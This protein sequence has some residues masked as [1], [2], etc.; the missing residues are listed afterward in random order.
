MQLRLTT[1]ITLIAA[2]GLVAACNE[3]SD[4]TLAENGDET[5]IIEETG[6]ET[7]STDGAVSSDVVVP[8]GAR[9]QGATGG[10]LEQ[11]MSG[12]SASSAAPEEMAG[13][14]SELASAQPA[15]N[16]P[17]DSEADLP[18]E[19]AADAGEALEEQEEAIEAAA[20]A[21]APAGTDAAEAGSTE[22]AD[23][24]A[25]VIEG[26]EAEEVAGGSADVEQPAAD[27]TGDAATETADADTAG[28]PEDASGTTE[29]AS[30][31]AEGTAE[32]LTEEELASLD[33]EDLQIEEG[34]GVERLTTFVEGSD[35][36]DATEKTTLIAGIE[37]AR[38]DPEQMQVLFD[39]I[40]EI[41][42]NAN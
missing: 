8:E 14:S 10:E 2:A 34:D 16:Q 3:E 19:E 5:V 11:A 1:A 40:K 36:F 37:A 25:A 23:A 31:E 32:P 13:E 41:A 27:M 28:Q 22:S 18:D 26:E 12:S 29:M 33:L 39:Q 7:A 35:A 38:D 20:D 4:T 9:V 21:T 42:S 17:L 24:E 30:T 6:T 15:E